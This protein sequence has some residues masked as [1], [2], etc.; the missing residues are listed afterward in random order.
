M[1]CKYFEIY[2]LN[3]LIRL[4]LNF[5]VKNIFLCLPHTKKSRP[6]LRKQ[7]QEDGTPIG[8]L[9]KQFDLA[10]AEEQIISGKC[11]R[12]SGHAGRP[13]DIENYDLTA[14]PIKH[15]KQE[16]SS[17]SKVHSF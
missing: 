8:K 11:L 4:F 6:S 2:V 17:K 9:Y 1:K 16:R 10:N 3:F 12:R 14:V 5:T 13:I 7:G 15:P